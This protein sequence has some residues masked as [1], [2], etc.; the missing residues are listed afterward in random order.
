MSSFVSDFQNGFPTDEI[1]VFTG[2]SAYK[3]MQNRPGELFRLKSQSTNIGSFFIG[4]ATGTAAQGLG[5]QIAWE[6]D[7]GDDTG[8]FKLMFNNLNSLYMYNPSGSSE[9]LV[10]WLQR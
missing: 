1:G 5:S 6:L 2:T 4:T 7:A 8:W 3:Q 10:Y 9:K